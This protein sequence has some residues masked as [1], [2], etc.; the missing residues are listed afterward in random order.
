MTPTQ[1]TLAHLR[2]R[3]AIAG[4]VE[5]FNRFAGP[6]GIRQDLFG[7][8]DIVAVDGNKVLFIQVSS[9]AGRSKR[10]AKIEASELAQFCLTAASVELHTWRKSVRKGKQTRWVLTV[11]HYNGGNSWSIGDA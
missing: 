6:H 7:F 9:S 3:G 8:C 10:R 2:K 4:V 5:R 11:E 1:R